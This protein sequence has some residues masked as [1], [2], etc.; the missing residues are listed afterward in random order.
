MPQETAN[1]RTIFVLYITG[2]AMLDLIPLV[3]LARLEQLTETHTTD[4]FQ[5][6]EGTSGGGIVA[7][8]MAMPDDADPR[9]PK[10]W[11]LDFIPEFCRYGLSFFPPVA[12]RY[13][14]MAAAGLLKWSED[15]IDPSRADA[16]IIGDIGELCDS[17]LQQVDPIL[18]PRFES[19]KNEG[20]AR[21]L[22]PSGQNKALEQCDELMS[23][24]PNL[25]PTITQLRNF[26]KERSPTGRLRSLWYGAVLGSMNLVLKTWARD[27]R[28]DSKNMGDA[29]KK[30][31]GDRRLNEARCSLYIPANDM[32]RNRL[33]MFFNRKADF[34]NHDPDAP[35]E[36][37]RGNHKIRDAV[38]A[39]TANG[40][41][42]LPHQTED[43]M[44]FD[45]K[46]PFDTPVLA[47]RHILKQKPADADVKVV[48]LGTGNSLR[49]DRNIE[50]IKL[51]A[52]RYGIPGN[53]LEGNEIPQIEKY[54]MSQAKLLLREDLGGKDHVIDITPRMVA[55]S[56]KEKQFLPSRDSL[57][58][59][60]ENVRKIINWAFVLLQERD[61]D[62]RSLAGQ[63]VENLHNIGQMSDEKYDRIRARLLTPDSCRLPELNLEESGGNIFT[64]GIQTL[65]DSLT[66][67]I[68]LILPAAPP[69]NADHKKCCGH[70]DNCSGPSPNPAITLP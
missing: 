43:G 38:L 30:F 6:L 17:L 16:E 2:G 59:S 8:G 50:Q 63:L 27:F 39:S 40:F 11:A 45:D 20:Q 44:L 60:P 35:G 62:I 56:R 3:V 31:L 23:Y 19:L 55:R 53:I 12:N 52:E 32:S 47:V 33:W 37:S 9:K 21:W 66:G 25:V 58:G 26:I 65:W 7:A 70:N 41:A 24:C 28:Y 29:Y 36:V 61:Q 14:K 69:A 15:K 42:V 48:I 67:L 68:D 49:D 5:V 54:I 57:D 22:T 10:I 64:E 13:F 4:L 18:K 51:D 34:F 1:N 46:A